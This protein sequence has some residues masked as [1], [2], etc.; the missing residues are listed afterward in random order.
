MSQKRLSM[1][2]IRELLRLKYDL[3]RS[4]REIARSLG[5]AAS[6]V[7]DYVRRRRIRDR[8]VAHARLAP[9]ACGVDSV[10][11]DRLGPEDRIAH[12]RVRRTA[13]RQPAPPRTGLPQ[14]PRAQGTAAGIR[15]RAP[16]GRLPPRTRHRHA[17]LPPPPLRK[18]GPRPSQQHTAKG[19]FTRRRPPPTPK[20]QTRNPTPAPLWTSALLQGDRNP[21]ESVIGMAE[22]VIG[23]VGMRI[24][25]RP[26]PDVRSV[27]PPRT[28]R[29]KGPAAATG[30]TISSCFRSS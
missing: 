12:S 4:H 14:L 28:T 24:R 9:R 19:P 8:T 25:R 13:P 11:T 2:K 3:G 1:R 21:P 30:V 22:L 29:P 6:T 27:V 26:G 10:P 7:S 5:I 15:R 18:T 23:I 17:E 16:G 20:L